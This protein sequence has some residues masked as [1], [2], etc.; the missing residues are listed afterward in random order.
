MHFLNRLRK[1][2]AFSNHSDGSE[3]K[4]TDT[5]PA[6]YAAGSVAAHQPTFTYGIDGSIHKKIEGLT[7]ANGAKAILKKK[8]SPYT[9]ALDHVGTKSD[10]SD[11]LV[12]QLKWETSGDEIPENMGY[13]PSK[14]RVLGPKGKK[15]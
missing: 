3:W 2:A 1:T 14:S 4:V 8:A 13:N 6:P 12:T 9:G 7:A 5:E 15:G 11:T 10:A